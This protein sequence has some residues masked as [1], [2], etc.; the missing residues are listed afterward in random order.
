MRKCVRERREERGEVGKVRKEKYQR[1]DVMGKHRQKNDETIFFVRYVV[2]MCVCV[3]VC[4]CA[5]VRERR[6]LPRTPKM[7]WMMPLKD[8]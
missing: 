4:M 8:W 3:C 2:C 1:K 7:V 5:C 6:G